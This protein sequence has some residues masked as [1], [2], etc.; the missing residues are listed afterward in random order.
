[1]G[2]IPPLNFHV[3]G[4]AFVDDE[5]KRQLLF[6]SDPSRGG[7][8]PPSLLTYSLDTHTVYI[9]ECPFP[10]FPHGA[11]VVVDGILYAYLMHTADIWAFDL[12]TK[13]WIPGPVAGL[14][15]DPSRTVYL[16]HI[17]GKYLCAISEDQQ[18]TDDELK[19][20]FENGFTLK[21][22]VTVF[23]VVQKK[24]NNNDDDGGGGL[25]AEIYDSRAFLFPNGTVLRECI[26]I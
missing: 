21:L 24:K 15:I 26:I 7:L 4:G 25:E 11:A 17:C 6:Y 5:G 3:R 8:L 23:K 12:A 9:A 22:I 14:N 2:P 20:F 19:E 18:L 1:M 13:R 16:K 10:M